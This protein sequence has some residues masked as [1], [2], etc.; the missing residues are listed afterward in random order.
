MSELKLWYILYCKDF[1]K[2]A[3]CTARTTTTKNKK[4]PTFNCTVNIF[5]TKRRKREKSG[6]IK[7]KQDVSL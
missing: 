3:Q 2:L 1:S 6:R 7:P 4:V 5:I